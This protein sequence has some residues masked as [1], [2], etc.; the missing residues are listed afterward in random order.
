MNNLD[1]RIVFRTFVM[2]K[3][4][5]RNPFADGKI[6]FTSLWDYLTQSLYLQSSRLLSV[7]EPTFMFVA[8]EGFEPSTRFLGK[9]FYPIELRSLRTDLTSPFI[10]LLICI[11]IY[12]RLQAD[13]KLHL[14]F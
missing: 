7:S 6:V 8:P 1:N 2:N 14:P 9:S 11:H 13:L 12:Y 5:L 10:Y 4:A 3:E